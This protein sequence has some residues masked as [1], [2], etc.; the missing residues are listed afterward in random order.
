M[1]QRE[2]GERKRERL[3]RGEG[4]VVGLLMTRECNGWT[5]KANLST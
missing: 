3:G 1:Y 5:L 4:M 2:K